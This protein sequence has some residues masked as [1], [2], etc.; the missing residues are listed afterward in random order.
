LKQFLRI[1]FIAELGFILSANCL[2]L[3]PPF[4]FLGMTL[5]LAQVRDALLNFCFG[6]WITAL[7]PCCN[8]RLFQR[9]ESALTDSVHYRL[10]GGLGRWAGVTKTPVVVFASSPAPV[11]IA[12]HSTERAVDTRFGAAD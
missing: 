7:D 1:N 3:S 11:R 10:N 5:V 12:A 4:F 2:A 6:S 9:G 8:Y